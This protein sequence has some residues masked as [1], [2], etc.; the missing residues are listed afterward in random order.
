MTE[1]DSQVLR[2]TGII[3][4]GL[5]ARSDLTRGTLDASPPFYLSR[6]TE[7]TQLYGLKK[8]NSR[9]GD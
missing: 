9:S 6:A 2:R 8:L 1:R 3:F 4:W 7:L 5:K